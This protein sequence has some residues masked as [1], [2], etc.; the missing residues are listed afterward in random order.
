[1][2]KR[3]FL[4]AMLAT[5]GIAITAKHPLE[6]VAPE[7]RSQT[8][9]PAPVSNSCCGEHVPELVDSSIQEEFVLVQQQQ[10]ELHPSFVHQENHSLSYRSREHIELIVEQLPD[11]T[12]ENY[13]HK[14][15]NFDADFATDIHLEETKSQLLPGVV[16]RLERVQA[17]VGH[18]NFNL[19]SFDEMLYFARNYPDIGSFSR[20]ELDFL[21]EIFNADATEYGFFGEKVTPNLNHRILQRDVVKIAHSSHYLMRG[22]SLGHFEQIRKDVGTQLQLTSGIRNNVKQMHL[23]LAKTL[24][25][26]GNLSKASRSLA[27][28]GYSFHNAGDFDVGKLGLGEKN[29]TADFSHTD[30]FKRLIRLGY[31]DIRYTDDNMFGVRFEPWH[32]K[33]A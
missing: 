20:P 26:Q 22:E 4:K 10:S 14:I 17:F 33:L 6:K 16:A 11:T 9:P 2:K 12:V 15:R 29:F 30:E 7:L 5:G 23:F 25:S 3:T 18:G 24:Q 13:L 19:L 27:P 8:S 28:P 32:I 31:V 21:E 1:M